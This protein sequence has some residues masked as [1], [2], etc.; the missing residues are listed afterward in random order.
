MTEKT[1]ENKVKWYLRPLVI[2]IILIAAGPFALGLVWKSP[3]FKKWHK[4]VITVLV[5]VLTLWLIKSSFEL[6][7]LLLKEL[8]SL[9]E[10]Q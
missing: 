5:L 10:I 4:I 7:Q 8:K 3:S 1:D 9:A 2:F 6:Y